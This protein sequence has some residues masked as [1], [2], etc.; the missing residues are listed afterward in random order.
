VKEA[1]ERPDPLN[2]EEKAAAGRGP[3]AWLLSIAPRLLGSRFTLLTIAL[4][5]AAALI[6]LAASADGFL[7]SQELAKEKAKLE[8]DIELLKDENRL[9]RLKIDSFNNNPAYLEDEGRKKLRLIRPE[10]T[11]YRLSE[12]PDLSDLPPQKPPNQ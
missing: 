12:E 4:I 9:L 11:I 1:A 2:S 7:K 8:A 3:L 5:G 10:E 6:Y